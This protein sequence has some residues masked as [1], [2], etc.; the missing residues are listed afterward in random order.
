[1]QIPAT[2]RIFDVEKAAESQTYCD[3][4]AASWPRTGW[5]SASCRPIWKGS[6]WR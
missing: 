5:L 3:D 1:V 4:I 6:W 2:I